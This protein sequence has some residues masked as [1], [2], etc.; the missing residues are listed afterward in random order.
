MKYVLVASLFLLAA[1]TGWG[2]AVPDST[3]PRTT[4]FS[5]G[6]AAHYGF[7][8]AHS[9]DV[10]NTRGARPVGLH[11]DLVWQRFDQRSWETCACY[12]RHG[13]SLNYFDYDNTVLG[14]GLHAAYFLEPTFRLGA[15]TSLSVRGA[16]GLSYLTNPYDPVRNPGNQ[17][18]SMPLS[19]YLSLGA[20]VLQR[21]SDRWA[22]Q[23][24]ASYLHTSNGG[25]QEPNKGINWPTLSL[26]VQYTP[27]PLPVPDRPLPPRRR[28]RDAPWTYELGTFLTTR[29]V[30][31]GGKERFFIGG[32]N[33]TMSRPIGR[34]HAWTITAE[35]AWD[36]VR[37]ERF[38]Q[39]QYPGGSPWWVGALTGHEFLLGKYRFGQQLGGYLYQD[40]PYYSRLYHRWYLVRRFGSA[41][42]AGIG[43][44]AHAQVANFLDFRA[45]YRL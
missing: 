1:G 45:Y 19:A 2:Q 43:L 17:S 40:A 37:R 6:L 3:V 9:A 29:T 14:R 38:R 25:I 27:C 12:P 31:V 33:A 18:Y 13:I 35:G 26:G 41:I 16:V 15:S 39:D 44:K 34:I 21:F 23:L 4:Q 8:F 30:G 5:L 28:Y 24:Q 22:A 42:H 32:L 10:E 7:I 20:G 36:G 11:I